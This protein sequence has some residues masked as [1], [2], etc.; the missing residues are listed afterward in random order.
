MYNS[1]MPLSLQEKGCT[2]SSGICLT[3]VL[4]KKTSQ[5]ITTLAAPKKKGAQS[6]ESATAAS[7]ARMEITA[8]VMVAAKSLIGWLDRKPSA[9]MGDYH[10]L[11]Q[12]I[13]KFSMDLSSILVSS[14]VH[15]L[16]QLLFESSGEV[17][18]CLSFFRSFGR[19]QCRLSVWSACLLSHSKT[20]L[21][22]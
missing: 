19:A 21:M 2:R 9:L 14:A 22:L 6:E 16:H 15:G 17:S 12:D 3:N 11:R 5:L 10:S 18:T 1:P 7:L 20:A 13:L 8:S 4:A